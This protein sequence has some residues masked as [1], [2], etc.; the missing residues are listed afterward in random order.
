MGIERDIGHLEG[1]VKRLEELLRQETVMVHRATRLSTLVTVSLGT[2]VLLFLV[3]NFFNF[4]AVFTEENLSRSLEQEMRELSPTAV[5]QLKVLG[6]DVVPV[7][8]EETRKQLNAMGP[9]MLKRFHDEVDQL[10]AA[11]LSKADKRLREAN[12]VV[13]ADTE[14]LLFQNLPTLRDPAEREELGRRFRVLVK[15]SV[16][17]SVGEFNGR[18]LEHVQAVEKTL[19][20][21]DLTGANVSPLVLQ[22]RF[23]HLWLQ[24]LDQEIMEL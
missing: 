15:D 3:I 14:E 1:E 12:D 7:Y 11:V 24:L 10:C 21:F 22:K 13:L 5:Q 19:W 23:I 20:E 18:L 9:E 6:E 4:R 8:A 17:K 2:L 16:I